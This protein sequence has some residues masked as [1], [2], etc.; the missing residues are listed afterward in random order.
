MGRV[1]IYAWVFRCGRGGL[2]Q[3]RKKKKKV[4]GDSF[5][6]PFTLAPKVYETL[7]RPLEAVEAASSNAGEALIENRWFFLIPDQLAPGLTVQR[8]EEF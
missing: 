2:K 7:P 5:L 1:G 8:R 3:L 4:L 6:F